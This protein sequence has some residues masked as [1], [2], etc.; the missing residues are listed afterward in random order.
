[1][2]LALLGFSLCAPV[3]VWAALPFVRGDGG[4]LRDGCYGVVSTR[5]CA[6]RTEER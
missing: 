1:M 2:W 6:R 4:A 5:R 3:L